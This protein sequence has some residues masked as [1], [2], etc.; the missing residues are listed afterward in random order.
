MDHSREKEMET[1]PIEKNSQENIQNDSDAYYQT[2]VSQEEIYLE[3]VKEELRA[4][5][6]PNDQSP[7]RKTGEYWQGRIEEL[8]LGWEGEIP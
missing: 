3:E 4:I 7:S 6:A 2:I 8:E 5:L 1:M